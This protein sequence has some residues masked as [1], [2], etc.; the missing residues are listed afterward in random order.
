[1]NKKLQVF[2]SSTYADLIEE[3]QAAVQAILDAGHIPAGMELFKA[4]NE[5][6]LKTIYKW[7]DESD[8][9]MLILG[10]RYGAI[11]EESG[12]SYTELEYQ[13]ALSKNMPVFSVV[14]SESYLVNKIHVL[15]LNK[16]VESELPDR[17]NH[18]KS[19]VM[20]KIIRYVD[21]CK[22]IKLAIYS[23][24][25]ELVNEYDFSNQN[26][27]TDK[28]INENTINHKTSDSIHIPAKED[29]TEAEPQQINNEQISVF[30][31]MPFSEEWSDDVLMAIKDTCNDLNINVFRADELLG[32]YLIID[33]IIASIKKS[34][35]IIADITIRNTNVYYELGY[36]HA[37][38]KN[39]ILVAQKGAII[40]FDISGFR[41][42]TYGLNYIKIKKF[43][44]ELLDN[45]KSYL[46]K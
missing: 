17:Y 46:P 31:I 14:L 2:V 44:K 9:Y 18:F 43:Q 24:L 16:T 22:D 37:L 38:N 8:V 20:S 15:G 34:D 39:T 10:G 3:R 32:S 33:D 19:I 36:A 4:G 11:D 29:E 25:N 5:S 28:E 7:I 30:I 6:Q 1:M 42:I 40:P 23:T 27:L 21:D 45:I 12:L 41:Y 13:Y 26:Q 35:I